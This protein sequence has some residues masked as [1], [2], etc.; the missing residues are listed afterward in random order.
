MIGISRRIDQ[1]GRIVIPVEVRKK[2]K[3]EEGNLLDIKLEDNCIVLSKS[4][5]LKDFK[6]YIQ[7]VCSSVTWCHFLVLSDTSVIFASEHYKKYENEKIVD[8]FEQNIL[9]SNGQKIKINICEDL[10]IDNMF[11]YS[12]K[13]TCFGDKHGY[14]CFLYEKEA[15]EKQKGAMQFVSDYI[16]SKL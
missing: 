7:D 16:S 14:A 3:I 4:E 2:L 11:I 1:L 8:N 15:T 9:S 10:S 5:P 13:L 12:Y 6:A